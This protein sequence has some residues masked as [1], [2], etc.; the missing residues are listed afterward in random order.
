MVMDTASPVL[1]LAT[2]EVVDLLGEV[3]MVSGASADL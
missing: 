2:F 3:V 1:L